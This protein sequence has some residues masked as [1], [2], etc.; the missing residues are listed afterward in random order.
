MPMRSRAAVSDWRRK[1]RSI[2][3]RP[4]R[5]WRGT[6]LSSTYSC[7]RVDPAGRWTKGEAGE[8]WRAALGQ[9]FAQA[10]KCKAG[11]FE[12][13]SA[14]SLVKEVF[15]D[16]DTDAGVVSALFGPDDGNPTPIAYAAEARALVEAIG[17][18]KHRALIHGGVL[19]NLPG[20]IEGM[21]V[22]ARTHRVSAWKLYPQWGPDGKGYFLDER[23][24]RASRL[25]AEGRRLGV[26]TIAVHKGVSLF[27]HGPGPVHRRGTWELVAKANP[28]LN[29]PGLSFRFPAGRQGRAIRSR[30]ARAWTG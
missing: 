16:S 18:G 13:Y 30:R 22:K 1:R 15:L 4:T 7:T 29:F 11:E 21:E 19:P 28:D 6:S 12:C 20:E 23:P 26:K 25:F 27:G 14:R 8:Q 24:A 10:R 2:E 5:P 9:A 17:G 3:P